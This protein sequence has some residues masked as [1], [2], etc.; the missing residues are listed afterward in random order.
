M[1]RS[2]AVRPISINI[3]NVDISVCQHASNITYM[4][5]RVRAI[6]LPKNVNGDY[7]QLL[8]VCYITRILIVLLYWGLCAI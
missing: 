3:N 4:G 7:S 8:T 5:V 1:P 6:C 2:Q